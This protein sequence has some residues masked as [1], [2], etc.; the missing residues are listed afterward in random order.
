MQDDFLMVGSIPKN[1][2]IKFVFG[3]REREPSLVRLG[4]VGS[5]WHMAHGTGVIEAQLS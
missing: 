2:I 1:R 3:W 5:I 4:N